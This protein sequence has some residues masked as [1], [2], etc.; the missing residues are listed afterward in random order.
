MM[1]EPTFC[2]KSR[3]VANLINETYGIRLTK[4]MSAAKDNRIWDVLY[5]RKPDMY[6]EVD[7]NVPGQIHTPLIQSK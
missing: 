1:I 3:R 5:P 6:R 2:E 7:E 4:T